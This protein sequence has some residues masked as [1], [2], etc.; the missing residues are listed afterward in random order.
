MEHCF[1]GP[2]H[3]RGSC[4]RTP[5]V[6]LGRGF[7]RSRTCRGCTMSLYQTILSGVPEPAP[8]ESK[9]GL[10]VT[11]YHFGY[12]DIQRR[13]ATI[14]SRRFQPL[15]RSATDQ[16]MLS[17]VADPQL[18]GVGHTG[19]T[20]RICGTGPGARQSLTARQLAFP[21]G[22]GCVRPSRS[23]GPRSCAWPEVA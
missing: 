2:F 8:F 6:T 14:R 11:S 4:P 5:P 12:H 23:V 3:Y 13:S 10:S 18:A 20:Y 7:W 19:G 16:S 17:P 15:T 21:V 22:R 9:C 1:A